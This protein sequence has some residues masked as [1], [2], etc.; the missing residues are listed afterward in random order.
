MLE[1]TGD[2]S[3]AFR[4]FEQERKPNTD[5]IAA[6]ALENYVE[7]RD[8]VRDP[9]FLLRKELSFELERRYPDRFIPRYSMVMFHHEIPYSVA[10]DRGRIQAGILERLT[11][12][13]TTLADVDM[14]RADAE[15]R[16]ALRPLEVP[17]AADQER[18]PLRA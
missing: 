17:A 8:T 9:K 3:R 15:V 12:R 1:A 18:A 4:A 10:Y 2:W 5:A 7:M 13:I 14:Q 16:A 6:M 11:E